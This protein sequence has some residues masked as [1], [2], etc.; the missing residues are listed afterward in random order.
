MQALREPEGLEKI[1]KV[2]E[3]TK[4]AEEGSLLNTPPCSVLT[5]AHLLR[6]EHYGINLGSRMDRQEPEH[7]QCHSWRF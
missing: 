5:S 3:L 6:T 1:R 7:I 4:F 2:R